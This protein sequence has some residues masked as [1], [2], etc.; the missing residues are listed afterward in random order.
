MHDS[1]L[2]ARNRGFTL[3]EIVIVISIITFVLGASMTAGQMQVKISNYKS[4]E[5]KLELAAAALELFYQKN[6]RYPCPAVRS[7][8]PT[9]ANYGI[10]NA[11]PICGGTS[12][13]G[14]V[15]GTGMPTIKYGALP[16]KT[17]GL[18][19]IDGLDAWDNKITYAI[20]T[21]FTQVDDSAVYGSI[22]IYDVNDNEM[23]ASPTTGDAYYVLLSH[24]E[25]M[26]GATLRTGGSRMSCTLNQ[27]DTENCDY[28]NKFID[29]KR[30]HSD[31]NTNYYDDIILWKT[32]DRPLANATPPSATVATITGGISAA[33]HHMCFTADDG[34]SWCWGENTSGKLGVGDTSIRNL[35]EEMT[36][37]GRAL[38]HW[39]TSRSLDTE[40]NCAI[41]DTG[42]PWCWGRNDEGQVGTG[43][44]TTPITSPAAVTGLPAG[45]RAVSIAVDRN[46]TMVALEDGRLYAFGDSSN[47]LFPD[48][49]TIALNPAHTP[50][51]VDSA[52]EAMNDIA[53][54]AMANSG[55][56]GSYK[57]ATCVL[58]TD[59]TT[60]CWG[61]FH[62]A[63]WAFDGGKDPVQVGVTSM[64]LTSAAG[65]QL[66]G[67]HQIMCLRN[68]VSAAE[69]N[70]VWCWGQ[71]TNHRL[72]TAL[73]DNWENGAPPDPA[74][75]LSIQYHRYDDPFNVPVAN[76]TNLGVGVGHVCGVDDNTNV[77]CWGDNGFAE[78]GQPYVAPAVAGKPYN[79]APDKV[80]ESESPDVEL[81]DVV[82]VSC[83]NTVCCAAKS[84]A[85]VVCWGQ[86]IHREFGDNNTV[87]GKNY[88][89]VPTTRAW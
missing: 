84:N 69:P 72:G 8:G 53:Q 61:N 37:A 3:V 15:I 44:F 32:Y 50:T 19:D 49:A 34:R 58:K 30:N 33:N 14:D 59:G 86:Q 51:Q 71:N 43:N 70:N 21:D 17:L 11:P 76:I 87:G 66:M 81:T 67:G 13:L 88:L 7:E 78:S 60:W 79:I 28:N 77:W 22:P 2:T 48:D 23:T 47:T 35:P 42:Q 46:S 39:S 38:E 40:H 56:G 9:D 68:E 25:N 20:D 89:P 73:V 12:T 1:Q 82:Q 80:L 31:D 74:P 83:G 63:F 10:E 36:I 57:R 65:A 16:F 27:K 52:S 64:A 6:Q 4:T 45:V 62:D 24:G 5:E 55:A 26:S 41:D 18:K 75:V 85:D 29:I 54:V